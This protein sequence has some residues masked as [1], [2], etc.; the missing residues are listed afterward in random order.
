MATETC[1]YSDIVHLFG[2]ISDHLSKEILDLEPSPAELEVAAA[3]AAGMTDVLGE[4]RAPL[5]GKAALIYD[6]V[7]RED[8]LEDDERRG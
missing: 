4:A 7:S 8:L 1:S 6:I 3:Y 5:T 2:P